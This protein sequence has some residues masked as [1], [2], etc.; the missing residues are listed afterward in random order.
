[1]KFFCSGCGAQL[2]HIRKAVPKFGTILDLIEPHECL[3]VAADPAQ[4]II[5]APISESDRDEFV[6]SL[7]DLK[8]APPS[9]LSSNAE[10]KS[11]RP[12]SMTGTDDLRDRRFDKEDPKSTAPSTVLDQIKQMSGSIP[13]HDLK[14]D[15][16]DSEMG[17]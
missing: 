12:S 9:R 8:P 17:G 13:A 2:N 4:V 11:L 7:N 6:K 10:G 3:E 16:T 1:M 14:D 15:T 5:A